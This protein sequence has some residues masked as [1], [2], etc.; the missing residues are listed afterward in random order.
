[1]RMQVL[2]GLVVRRPGFEANT[3]CTWPSS[4]ND[5]AGVIVHPL[6]AHTP[7]L[8]RVYE[9]CTLLFPLML[10]LNMVQVLQSPT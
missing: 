2:P 3:D 4:T 10:E 1:M 9:H 6:V 7:L 5:T 8:T